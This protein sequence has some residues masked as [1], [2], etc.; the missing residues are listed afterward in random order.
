MPVTFVKQ[1]YTP[2]HIIVKAKDK[3]NINIT[4]FVNYMTYYIESN[5]QEMHLDLDLIIT[6][7][8]CKSNL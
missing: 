6:C 3:D 2:R 5:I 8:S 1:I 7:I 4:I